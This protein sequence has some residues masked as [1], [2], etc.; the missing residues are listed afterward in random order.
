MTQIQI[1]LGVPSD[2]EQVARLCHALWPDASPEEHREEVMPT[3]AGKPPGILPAAIFV[4]QTAAGDL[5]GFLEVSLRSH[6]DGCDVRH[7]VGFLEGWF[8]TEGERGRGTGAQL[9]AAAEN[10]ARRQ[11]CREMASDTW[12]DSSLSQRVHETLKFEVVDR[13]VH[14]RKTL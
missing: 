10:W 11:G 13:C 4:A 2:A 6:A 8:V 12:I 1:R 9:L 7:P 3:L 14:Y 5:V